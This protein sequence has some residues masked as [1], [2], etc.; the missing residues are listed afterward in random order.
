VNTRRFE[1][2]GG[3]AKREGYVLPLPGLF[4]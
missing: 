4:Y 3:E 1:S 2:F